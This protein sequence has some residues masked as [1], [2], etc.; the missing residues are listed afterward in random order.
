MSTLLRLLRLY[1]LALWSGGLVFFIMVAQIAF[2]TLPDTHLAGVIV[3]NSLL[4][5]HNIG[6]AAGLIYFVA[7][8]LLLASRHEGR[9]GRL[10]ELILVLLMLAG[11]AYS[12]FSIIPRMESDRIVLGGDVEKAQH[13]VSA[14]DD[15]QRLHHA[16]TKLGGAILIGSLLL[17]ALSLA[18]S[19]KRG[20]STGSL[21][22]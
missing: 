6:L 7:T 13:N 18:G 3:R 21:A 19:E 22:L 12:K 5:I 2:S 20:Y 16:S 15:F 14:Y 10:T 9:G 17:I 8:L 4:R 1:T 11:T